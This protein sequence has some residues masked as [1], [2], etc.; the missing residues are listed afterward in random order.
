MMRARMLSSGLIS[1]LMTAALLGAAPET[2]PGNLTVGEFA[3]LIASRTSSDG[4]VRPVAAADA[5]EILKRSGIKIKTSLASPLTEGDAADLFHQFGITLQ[6]EHADSVLS[7]DRAEALVAVFG[8]TLN[9]AS[10]AR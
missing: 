6:V 1:C 2:R 5:A 8:S 10:I 7:R 3:A 9:A 4:V